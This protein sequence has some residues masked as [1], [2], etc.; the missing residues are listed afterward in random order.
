MRSPVSRSI[1]LLQISSARLAEACPIWLITYPGVAPAS[2]YINAQ[3]VRRR[4][5]FVSPSGSVGLP[6]SAS[7]SFARS[8]AT[9]NT[10]ERTFCLVRLVPAR[11]GLRLRHRS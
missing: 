8:T 11:S 2:Y 9:A 6:A 4:L 1:T 7:A 5:W 3:N 10:R